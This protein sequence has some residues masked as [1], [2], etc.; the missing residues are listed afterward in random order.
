MFSGA[1]AGKPTEGRSNRLELALWWQLLRRVQEKLERNHVSMVSAGVAF[2]ALLSIFPAL[3]VLISIYGLVA[4]RDDVLHELDLFSGILPAEAVK[5]LADQMNSLIHAPPA[6]LG[7][8]FVVSLSVALWSAMSG[9]TGLMQALTI[10]YN[11]PEDRGSL[12]FYLTAAALTAGFIL[13]SVLALFLIA[14]IPAVLD[15][16]TLPDFWRGAVSL[17]LWPI[18]AGLGVVGLS[19]VYRLAPSR[20]AK[21]WISTGAIASALFWIIGSFGFSLYVARFGSYDKTYG[22]L[23]AV[24]ILLMWFYLT[25][26]IIL[27]GAELNAEIALRMASSDGP[28]SR[29]RTK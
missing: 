22:S 7:V 6:K 13:F 26:Y 5:L 8:G 15:W 4:D 1:S 24:V 19:V 16:L 23:G 14:V 9:T 27:A 2:Y 25:A 20:G 11:E 10:A 18:L 29:A 3:S 12:Q 28:R 21:R 17:I